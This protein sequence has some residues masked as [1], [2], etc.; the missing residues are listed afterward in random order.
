[1][2][3]ARSQADRYARAL[4]GSE[5]WPPFL[6]VVDVGHSIELFSEFTRSGRLYG[7]ILALDPSRR[8]R[9]RSSRRSSSFRR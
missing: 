3:A 2:I 1:M 8:A 6:I 5:G 4:P 9:M 7:P